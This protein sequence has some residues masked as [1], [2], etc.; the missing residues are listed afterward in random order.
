MAWYM[1]R[2]QRRAGLLRRISD[3]GRTMGGSEIWFKIGHKSSMNGPLKQ[4]VSD[5]TTLLY[6]H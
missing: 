3:R 5:C 6:G 1:T 4:V 2:R